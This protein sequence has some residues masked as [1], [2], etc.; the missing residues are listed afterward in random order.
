MQVLACCIKLLYI[1]YLSGVFD[2]FSPL[3]GQVQVQGKVQ[4]S[5]IVCHRK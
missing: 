3:T 4:A 1:E 5:A 2:D